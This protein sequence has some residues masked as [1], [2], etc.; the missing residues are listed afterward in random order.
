MCISDC[1]VQFFMRE[2]S[3]GEAMVMSI[4]VAAQAVS[5]VGALP[6]LSKHI[7]Y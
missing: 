4:H 3:A 6:S 1:T 7:P 5:N 2:A